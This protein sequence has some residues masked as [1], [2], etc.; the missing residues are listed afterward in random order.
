MAVANKAKLLG[1]LF[2]VIVQGL[3]CYCRR[4]AI[5]VVDDQ[6]I[7]LVNS[8]Y[9][10]EIK[11]FKLVVDEQCDTGTILVTGNIIYTHFHQAGVGW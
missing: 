2:K 1:P 11:M 7:I 10:F 6:S 3:V 5:I 9:G 8:G 4:R